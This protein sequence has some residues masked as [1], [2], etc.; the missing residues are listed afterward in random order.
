MEAEVVAQARRGTVRLLAIGGQPENVTGELRVLIAATETDGLH[1][2]D[3]EA[4]TKALLVMCQI[5][6]VASQ[7][8]DLLEGLVLQQLLRDQWAKVA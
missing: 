6:I 1:A 5:A 7:E 8:M 4:V 3:V 2:Q